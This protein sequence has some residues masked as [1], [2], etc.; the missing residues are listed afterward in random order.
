MS[1][2]RRFVSCDIAG[3]VKFNWPTILFLEVSEKCNDD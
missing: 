2:K 1:L 3:D